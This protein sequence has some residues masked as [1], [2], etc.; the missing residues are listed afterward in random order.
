[1]GFGDITP[2]LPLARML[3]VVT[4]VAGPLYLATVMG[5]LIGRY[6]SEVNGQQA[7]AKR[8]PAQHLE[9]GDPSAG[10]PKP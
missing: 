7:A 8:P 9:P 2:T 3:S 6:T 5:V 4:S 10:E 1:M